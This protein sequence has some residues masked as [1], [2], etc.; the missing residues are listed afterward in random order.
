MAKIVWDEVGEKIYEYGAKNGVLYP[1]YDT[2]TKAFGNGVA[3]NGL[4]SVTQSRSGADLNKI[5]ADD[6]VY[7]GI[8][9]AEDFGGTIECYTTPPE[10]AECD[11]S[12]FLAKGV[13]V[14]QQVRKPFG[15]A[16]I[17][18]VANDTEGEDFGYTLHLVYNATASPYEVQYQTKNDSPEAATF[19]IEF[20]CIPLPCTVKD[21]AGEEVKSL[22]LIE[23]NS[24]TLDEQGKTNLKTLEDKLFGTDEAEPTL[25]LPED[26]AKI[27]SGVGA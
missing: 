17:S 4:T 2:K 22:S 20:S 21:I 18:T 25:P 23:I 15:F 1:G 13:K 8:R 5:Y 11:G 6:S 19:S 26:V 16:Y 12:K 3:W 27:M 24:A 10:F 7:A 9:G 14:N